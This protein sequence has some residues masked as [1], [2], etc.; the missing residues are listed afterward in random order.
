MNFTI[1]KILQKL[2][3]KEIKKQIFTRFVHKW[4]HQVQR[5]LHYHMQSKRL[6]KIPQ[7]KSSI[8]RSNQAH[9]KFSQFLQI[10]IVSEPLPKK[11]LI[12]S[13]I[14][15]QWIIHCLLRLHFTYFDWTFFMSI[16]SGCF[17][18][19]SKC[20]LK[21]KLV[22]NFKFLLFYL[23]D[24]I[25]LTSNMNVRQLLV[26]TRDKNSRKHLKSYF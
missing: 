8:F 24:K 16:L 19:W 1:V 20:Q 14:N 18:L 21:E 12:Y 25:F 5:Q 3:L 13:H 7:I 15:L 4:W 2:Y 6:R 10:F 9:L 23:F 26:L 11:L 17:L 22:N